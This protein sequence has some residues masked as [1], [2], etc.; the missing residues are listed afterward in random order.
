MRYFAFLLVFIFT[1]CGAPTEHA[2]HSAHEAPPPP[3]ST[4]LPDDA[5]SKMLSA[6]Y[7]V[8][9]TLVEAD[10][11]AADSAAGVLASLADGIDV[12]SIISDSSRIVVATSLLDSVVATAA[13]LSTTVDLTAR[14][15]AFSRVGDHLLAFIRNIGY[16]ASTVY[17]Q[18]CPMAFDDTGKASWLSNASAIVNPY[19]GKKHPKYSAGMLHCG[20][21]K[22]SIPHKP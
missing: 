19:L 9:N 13:S 22:D 1:A 15:R 2:D 16:T 18:E 5:V 4:P 3:P 8:K 6:Y 20:E 12:R 10:S 11:V 21:L 7:A 14:R 17:V